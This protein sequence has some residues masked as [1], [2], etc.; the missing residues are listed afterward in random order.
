MGQLDFFS[1][2]LAKVIPAPKP[3]AEEVRVAMKRLDNS[4]DPSLTA[5]CGQW[6]RNLGYLDLASQVRVRWS[7]RMQSTA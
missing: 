5:L 4:E 6:L 1:R 7:S 2:L 3:I